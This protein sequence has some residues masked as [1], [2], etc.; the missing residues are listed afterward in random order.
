MLHAIAGTTTITLFILATIIALMN[1]AFVL[2]LLPESLHPSRRLSH[3]PSHVDQRSQQQRKGVARR[4]AKA[5]RNVLSQF[6]LPASLFVPFKL[7]GRRGRD[8]NL[9]LT[10]VALFLYVFADVS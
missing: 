8:W 10:G 1:F 4:M 5:M 6:L 7:E 9:T 2:F 3:V